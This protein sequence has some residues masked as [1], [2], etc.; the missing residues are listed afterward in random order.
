MVLRGMGHS[1]STT[2]HSSSSRSNPGTCRP[3]SCSPCTSSSQARP[4]HGSSSKACHSSSS[5]L[6]GLLLGSSSTQ[7]PWASRVAILQTLQAWAP[8]QAAGMLGPRQA[9]S[10]KAMELPC[11]S[12]LSSSHS[13]NEV[14]LGNQGSSSSSG[15]SS[16]R[17][18]GRRGHRCSS[19]RCLAARVQLVRHHAVRPLHS[20][21]N[22]S[23]RVPPAPAKQ[24]QRRHS[25]SGSR[26]MLLVH[27]AGL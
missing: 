8:P 16:S 27:Q 4:P 23:L 17:Q 22:S 5:M 18:Q 2:L 1:S 12:S 10:S 6:P 13:S 19:R 9:S 20:S 26:L 24:Q 25:S 21:S 3:S 7:V 11:L 15:H 14:R